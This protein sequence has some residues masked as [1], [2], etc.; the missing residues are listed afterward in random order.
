MTDISIRL[1]ELVD[2]FGGQ[3]IGNPDIQVVGIAPLSDA[4]ARHITFLS[5]SKFRAQAESTQAAA[6][7][8]SEKDHELLSDAYQGARLLTA[9]PYVYFA[10]AAQ[11]F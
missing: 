7:I 8:L 11:Y 1:G 3:L 10:K 6:L 5:N 2:R 4:S 9:N